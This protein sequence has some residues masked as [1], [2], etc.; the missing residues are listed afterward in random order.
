MENNN[1][2]NKTTG[3]NRFHPIRILLLFCVNG[4]SGTALFVILIPMLYVFKGS[5]VPELHTLFNF[6]LLGFILGG[7]YGLVKEF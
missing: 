5:G 6:A 7:I 1:L 2:E 4:L 3:V